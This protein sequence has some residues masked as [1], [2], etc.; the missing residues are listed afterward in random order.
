MYQ[1]PTAFVT[2][3][4]SLSCYYKGTHFQVGDIVSMTDFSDPGI[5]YA[6]IRGFLEDQYC[7]KSA[8]V[9]WLLP[10]TETVFSDI[11]GSVS[12]GSVSSG[13]VAIEDFDPSTFILGPEEDIPRPLEC[14]TFVSHCPS[15]YF[16]YS[17]SPYPTI[18]TKPEAGF[19][20]TRFGHRIVSKSELK[21]LS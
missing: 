20:W 17:R 19:I 11:S 15:D 9:T 10:T 18:S 1:A 5:Y 6:Q 13:Y 7:E 4:T 16:K 12:S 14:M 2:P 3:V 8:S 21:D